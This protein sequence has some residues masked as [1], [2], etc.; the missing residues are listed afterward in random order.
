MSTANT[1]TPTKTRYGRDSV[2]FARAVAFF[3]AIYAF[4]LTLLVVN[5]DPPEAAAWTSLG[6][7]LD[8]GLGSQLLGFAISF[9]VIPVF[10]RVNHRLIARF[11]ARGRRLRR[12]HQPRRARPDRDVLRGQA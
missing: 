8:S 2:E 5:V 10:W 11:A 7:L 9:I 1:G 3:D 6:A 12:E 4:A